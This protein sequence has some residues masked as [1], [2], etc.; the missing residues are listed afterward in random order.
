MAVEE[1]FLSICA[2]LDASSFAPTAPATRHDGNVPPIGC[3][4]AQIG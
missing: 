4:Q 1:R 3:V 2:R